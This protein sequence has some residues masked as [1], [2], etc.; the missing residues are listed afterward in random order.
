MDEGKKEQERTFGEES[1]AKWLN[2][3]KESE[4]ERESKL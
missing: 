1:V 2:E 4:M 3:P